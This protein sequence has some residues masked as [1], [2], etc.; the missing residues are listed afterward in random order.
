MSIDGNNIRVVVRA[1]VVTEQPVAGIGSL[2]SGIAGLQ[3]QVREIW[4]RYGDTDA[5]CFGQ[6]ELEKENIRHLHDLKML[7]K[8]EAL[9]IITIEGNDDGSSSSEE[10][11]EESA[12]NIEPNRIEGAFQLRF[13]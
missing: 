7:V 5:V 13:W 2:T 9:E 1:P 8:D 10:K 4:V 11:G 3:L 12:S 6:K